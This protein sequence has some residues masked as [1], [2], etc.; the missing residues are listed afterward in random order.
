MEVKENNKTL[1]QLKEEL[2]QLAT[3]NPRELLE[4]S[5][6]LFP[7]LTDDA[8][9]RLSH[10]ATWGPFEV[11]RALNTLRNTVKQAKQAIK[12]ERAAAADNPRPAKEPRF[13]LLSDPV[14]EQL[15]LFADH[16]RWPRRPYCSDDKTASKIRGLMSAIKQPY[17]Q[18]NPP[19]LRVWSIFDVDREGGG[20]AWEGAG[21]PPPTWAAINKENGH[22]HLSWGLSA[23]VLVE[24]PE[25]R[26]GPLRY[27]V[28]VESLMRERLQA[29]QGFGGLIT[30][31]P[32]HPLWRTLRG[33]QMFY[34][35]G[36]L[37]E[38]LPGLE[39][40]IPK[41]K[42]RVEEVGLG[43][44]CALFDALRRWSYKH[45]KPYRQEGKQG[46]SAW[47][48]KVNSKG[49]DLNG[50]FR[51]PLDG[52]EVWHIAKSVAKWTWS[53]FDIAASDKR[54]SALQSHRGK[55]GGRP[56]LGEPWADMG[57]SRRTYFRRV[58][59]GLIVP[60]DV[61]DK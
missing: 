61:V 19:H 26:Q 3:R 1:D 40:H 25:L 9:R 13:S 34:E 60:A 46:W 10:Y 42:E 57:I 14:N 2:E 54:F 24:S 20:L 33:P 6:R 53:K 45:V 50:E 8:K 32:A 31:N 49:L 41:K 30:K 59:S 58:K 37:A 4:R 5:A 55:Q 44:N 38:Y 27:L 16:S 43:R 39:Q 7:A 28:A 52:T 56:A 23:P 51:Y 22:A 15:D 12:A 35:L 21:L 11:Q 48:S 18:A 29:D 47:V 17:L 36:E